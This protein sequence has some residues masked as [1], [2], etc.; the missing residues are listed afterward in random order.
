MHR[1]EDGVIVRGRNI[2]N[3]NHHITRVF[4]QDEVHACKEAVEGYKM[5]I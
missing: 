2:P 4:Y 1:M 3:H 5:Q